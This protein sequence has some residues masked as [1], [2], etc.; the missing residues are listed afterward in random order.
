M[1]DHEP[2]LIQLQQL[3]PAALR[4]FHQQFYEPVARYV[5]FKVGDRQTVEDLCGETFVRALEAFQRGQGWQDSARGWVMGIA[6]NVVADHYRRSSRRSEVSLNEQITSAE[7]AGPVQHAL[8]RERN[9]QLV[10]A[11]QQLTDE[12]RDVVL[13]RFIEGLDIQSVARALNKKPGAI[14]GLQFRAL[15]ALAALMRDTAAVDR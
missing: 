11:I 2:V 1:T 15:R 5:Q 14:K 8:R 9:Q 6:R 4:D 10:D 3:D 12:Q 7:E 13:M